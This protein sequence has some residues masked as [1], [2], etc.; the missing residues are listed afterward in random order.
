MEF[1]CV[2]VCHM[3]HCNESSTTG[4]CSNIILC[5]AATDGN[6]AVWNLGRILFENGY[7]CNTCMSPGDT[8]LIC[9]N[10]EEPKPVKPVFCFD[11]AH[12]SGI[13]DIYIPFEHTPQ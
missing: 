6:I 12:Q 3:T 11:K 9:N 10:L 7:F 1:H 5:T 13:N 4:Q 8:D 2:I